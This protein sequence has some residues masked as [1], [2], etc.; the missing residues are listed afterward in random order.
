MNYD[1]T[2]GTN[3]NKVVLKCCSPTVLL[4]SPPKKKQKWKPFVKNMYGKNWRTPDL[5]VISWKETYAQYFPETNKSPLRI[6]GWKM[7]HV[8]FEKVAKISGAKWLFCRV[9]VPGTNTGYRTDLQKK[10]KLNSS[11]IGPY[12]SKHVELKMES[13]K[14]QLHNSFI[15]SATFGS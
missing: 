9:R 11:W 2:F 4:V 5:A 8:L 7:I 13:W 15:C 14:R 12:L 10:Y 6:S 1:L 3:M